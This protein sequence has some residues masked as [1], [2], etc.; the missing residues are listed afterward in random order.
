MNTLQHDNNSAQAPGGG[1]L[2]SLNLKRRLLNPLSSIL[3]IIIC[4]LLGFFGTIHSPFQYD[5][6]HAI[7]ENPYIKDL[8]KF[9][10]TVGFGNIFNRSILLLT[11]AINMDIGGVNVFG[12]HL[13][14]IFIHICVGI[15]ILFITKELAELMPRK[16]TRLPLL[17]ALA[18]VLQPLTVEP[19]AYLSSRSALL[20]TLFY[21]LSF[22][23]F[24]RFIKYRG[25]YA[26]TRYLYLP[27]LSLA[28]FALGTGTKETIITLPFVA[29]VYLWI[30]SSPP[31]SPKDWLK[32]FF[33]LSPVWLYLMYRAMIMGNPFRVQA[34]ISLELMNRS[35][36]FLTE[37]KVI[38]FYY[39]LKWFLPI[40]LNFEPHI[41]MVDG[42]ADLLIALGI[43]FLMGLFLKQPLAKFAMIWALLTVLPESSFIPLK[44]MASEHRTYLPGVGISLL[45]GMGFLHLARSFSLA[46]AA[47]ICIIVLMAFLTLSRGL[48]YRTEVSLWEDTVRKSPGKIL[49]HN[50]LAAIYIG[51]KRYEDARRELQT[52]LQLE[53]TYA[54]AYSNLGLLHI[55][56]QQWEDAQ[57]EFE[58]AL[59]Y[60]PSNDFNYAMIGLVRNNMG[61]PQEAISYLE[62]A[63]ELKPEMPDYHFTLGNSYRQLKQYDNALKEYRLTLQ[64]QPNNA[65]AHNSIAV[66]FWEMKMYPLATTALKQALAIDKK[67]V[68]ILSNLAGVYIVQRQF[69]EAIPH[70]EHI[71]ALQPENENAINLLRVA[72]VLKDENKP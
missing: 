31:Y 9:Q 28:F 47:S 20:V 51:K 68:E 63:I 13:A 71:L 11:F 59:L 7:V 16:E 30:R 32:W 72:K 17:V 53:P 50:N 56:Q 69:L 39:L 35:Q 48:V 5:D 29:L 33:V 64:Y 21:L 45:M 8:S 10:E 23:C 43:L 22:Y 55:R 46:R 62:R 4:G 26:G 14:N 37:I 60:D 40:G 44:Q 15:L 58:Q 57:K 70:L 1:S 42:G 54:N 34:D 6:A 52:I 18:Y 41:R 27:I 3:L 38:V 65:L 25:H 24:I 19:V 2:N 49:V 67:N 36:Y 66:V 61:R 12:Y